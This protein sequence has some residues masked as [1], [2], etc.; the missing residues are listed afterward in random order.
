M[1]IASLRHLSSSSPERAEL[2]K[3]TRDEEEREEERERKRIAH[4][5]PQS[6]ERERESGRM[7]KK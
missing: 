3:K 6:T 5:P 1:T 2:R 7:N 4:T